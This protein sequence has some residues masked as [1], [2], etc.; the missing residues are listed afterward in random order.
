MS[1]GPQATPRLNR[2][3][4]EPALPSWAVGALVGLFVLATALAGYLVF[5]SVRDFVASWQITGGPLGPQVADG[6]PGPQGSSPV[7][8]PDNT[9]V[10][11]QKWSGTDRVTILILG[12]DRR[13]GDQETTAFRSDT[14]LIASID[15]AA[16]TAVML[17]IPRD[18]WVEIPDGS[19]NAKITEANFKGD[20][21]QYPGGGPALAMKTVKHNLGIG[22]DHYVRIDFTAFETLVDAIGGIEVDN[23]EGIDDP[24]YPDG[25][26]GFEPFYLAA[27]RQ[28]LNG[29]DALRYA[30]TRH[31]SSDVDRAKR[32]Q[33]V[34]MAVREKVLSTQSLPQLLLQAPTLYQTLNQ[35]IQTDL[36]LDQMVS[37]ALLAQDIPRDQITQAV[38]DYHYVEEGILPGDPP[39]SV[40]IPLRDKIR[41]L[42]ADLFTT[43]A[44]AAPVVVQAD[45]PVA[46]AAEG[47]RVEVLNGAGVEGLAG[48]TADWLKGQGINVVS[49]DTASRS[50][51]PNS[52]IVVYTTKPYTAYWLQKT[53][54]VTT[55]LN[56][57]DPNSSVDV[58]IILGQDW[59]APGGP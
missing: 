15:P 2:R 32:Q 46:R 54:N 35:S 10:T 17:S 24:D 41:E 29:H 11:F 8:G 7:G 58:Q 1:Q 30:R 16:K 42:V 38:I 49:V 59:Q 48:R 45:D 12:I 34:V 50:D 21:Y 33:Q 53:F 43:S 22:V 18:L 19:G 27:G 37:L 20:A 39:Q 9:S 23:P 3:K 25:G 13:A 36:T 40:L 56:G 4:R 51:Y 26:Y 57:A 31:E 14:M 55:V 6:T 47:A 5:T 52:V 44:A 28:H